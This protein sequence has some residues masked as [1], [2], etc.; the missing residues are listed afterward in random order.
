MIRRR[1]SETCENVT[2]V[3]VAVGILAALVAWPVISG[4]V[5]K[6]WADTR[7]YTTVDAGPLEELHL[8]SNGFCHR[9]TATAVIHS[10]N[11][12]AHI[13]YPPVDPNIVC[14]S[15]DRVNSFF[16]TVSGADNFRL[17]VQN[18]NVNGTDAILAPLESYGGWIFSL[19]LSLIVRVVIIY[20]VIREFFCKTN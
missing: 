8:R 18:P 20:Y 17:M 2:S 10:T 3:I 7:D 6:Q 15:G 5:V 11:M 16:S 9:A 19:V 4:I 1:N 12:T 14:R 13:R